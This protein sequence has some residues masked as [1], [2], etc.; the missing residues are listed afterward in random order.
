MAASIP[1]RAGPTDVPGWQ[2][3]WRRA[4]ANGQCVVVRRAPFLAAGGWARV[5]GHLVEDVALARAVRRGGGTVGFV[6]AADLLDVR[7]YESARETWTGWSRSLMSPDVNGPVQQALDLLVLWTCV[8][9]PLPRLLLRRR[10]APGR[11]PDAALL[12]ARLGFHAAL[13]RSY[14]PRGAPYWAAPL[15]DLP[16]VAGLTWSALRPR[17]TW[18]GRSYPSSRS[19]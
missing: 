16:V 1:Y 11:W 19:S 9:L 6:D 18:R 17:R 4:N 10:A 5:R 7:M 2:P 8:A 13:A 15:L 14:R 12:A 3:P